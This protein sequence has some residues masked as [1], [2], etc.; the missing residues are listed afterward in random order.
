MTIVFVSMANKEKGHKRTLVDIESQ[1]ERTR[2]ELGK[3]R[4][5]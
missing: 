1:Q 4:E 3:G 5:R 2:R